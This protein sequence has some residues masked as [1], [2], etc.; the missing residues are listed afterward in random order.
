MQTES[1]EKKDENDR[2]DVNM[3][4]LKAGKITDLMFK[5]FQNNKKTKDSRL[6]SN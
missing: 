1:D 2:Y 3:T 4:C 5:E 6:S